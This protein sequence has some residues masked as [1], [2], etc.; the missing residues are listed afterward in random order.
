MSPWIIYLWGVAD[1]VQRGFSMIGTFALL[2]AGACYF[3]ANM[4]TSDAS[5]KR[6]FAYG[7]DKQRDI[8]EADRFDRNAAQYRKKCS[9]LLSVGYCLIFTA[10]LMP[11]S[12]TIA[13]MVV[14]PAVLN[15]EP[16]QKDLPELYQMAKEAFKET[17]QTK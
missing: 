2:F 8:D 16:I 14:V 11:N 13:L 1:Q 17:L 5:R 6:Q 12:K 15:S 7:E 4:L 3:I 9:L 10:L